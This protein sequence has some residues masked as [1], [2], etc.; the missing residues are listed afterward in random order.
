MLWG[1]SIRIQSGANGSFGAIKFR[2]Q[3]GVAN[4]T[5]THTTTNNNINVVTSPGRTWKPASMR[6]HHWGLAVWPGLGGRSTYNRLV[7]RFVAVE[8]D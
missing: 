3:Q 5:T 6:G 2:F 4:T 8:R 7:S 1:S